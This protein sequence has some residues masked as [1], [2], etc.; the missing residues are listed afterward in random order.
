ME[1]TSQF[2][3]NVGGRPMY[4]GNSGEVFWNFGYRARELRTDE[5]D[6]EVHR[7]Q[8]IMP[9]FQITGKSLSADP[10]VKE[11][12]LFKLWNHPH[13]ITANGHAY[14]GVHQ[15]TGSCVGAG[16]GNA[17]MT[18]LAIQAITLRRPE[19]ALVPFWLLPYG[20]SR[21][22]IGDRNPGEGSTGAT[23][24]KALLE[25]GFIPAKSP[26]L[27]PYTTD[28]GLTWGSKVELAWSDGDA[29]QTI[30]LLPKSRLHLVQTAAR[31]VDHN[32]V[33]EGII[34]GYPATCA[35][36]YAHD[37]GKVQG[38]PP[39]LLARRR[40][41]WSH[42]MSHLAWI[43]HP[44]FGELFW[45]MNQWGLR[46]HGICPTGAPPGG[47]WITAEDVDYQCRDEVYLLSGAKGFPAPAPTRIP[48]MI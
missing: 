21:F 36:G 44:E 14:T 26:G 35:S 31:A 32:D 11:A 24:A 33:R 34:N 4:R 45:C 12:L 46:A 3:K 22:Y 9:R 43:L 37:G 1:L 40:G 8:A 42:Q 20:R 6:A 5:E 16:G 38:N 13:V 28:D 47:V 10:T 29:P 25:D 48:W 18:L 17:V 2:L 41:S 15:I 27:P 7:A 23:F 19:V 39:V 30:A